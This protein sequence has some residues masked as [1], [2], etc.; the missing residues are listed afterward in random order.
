MKKLEKDLDKKMFIEI[1]PP[2][3]PCAKEIENFHLCLFLVGKN[4]RYVIK[5]FITIF[6][7]V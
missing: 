7:Y 3:F 6:K 5:T 2:S 1:F 4:V